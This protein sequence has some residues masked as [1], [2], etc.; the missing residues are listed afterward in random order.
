MHHVGMSD[1]SLKTGPVLY[2]STHLRTWHDVL[3]TVGTQGV[4]CSS[5]DA[6]IKHHVV[7]TAGHRLP[8]EL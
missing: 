3:H 1:G 2:L 5:T 6:V 7:S 4:H 8:G